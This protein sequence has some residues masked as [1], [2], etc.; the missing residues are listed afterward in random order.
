[1]PEEYF[2]NGI[3]DT[4]NRVYSAEVHYGNYQAIFIPSNTNRLKGT[5]LK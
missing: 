3:R 2:S 5:V 4:E 1:M